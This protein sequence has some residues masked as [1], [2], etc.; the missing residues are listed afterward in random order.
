LKVQ[1][2]KEEKDI[3]QAFLSIKNTKKRSKNPN[4]LQA[5]LREFEENQ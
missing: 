4:I 3:L 5:F 2:S 1:P